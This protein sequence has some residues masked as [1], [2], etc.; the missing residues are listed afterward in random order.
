MIH[1]PMLAGKFENDEQIAAWFA[2]H[3]T[4]Y[5]TVKLDGIRALMVNGKL[6]SRTFKPIPNEWARTTLEKFLPEGSDG[7]LI[8]LGRPIQETTSAVMSQDGQPEGLVFAWFDLYSDK[9]YLERVADIEWY[10]NTYD[11]SQCPIRIMP[12]PVTA[13]NSLEELRGLEEQLVARGEEGVII[14]SATG[15]YKFGRSTLKEG[16][17]LKLKRFS[18]DTARA[19][20]FVELMHNDNEAEEDAFGRTKRSKCQENLVPMGTLGALVVEDI[21]TGVQFEIG[22]GFTANDRQEIWNNREVILGRLCDYKHFPV[23]KK[24]KP[25]HPVFVCWRHDLG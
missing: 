13:V 22:T 9:P 11:L 17:L 24:D 23:G 16:S 15:L 18:Q 10:M 25:R 6:V 1:K 5:C 2:V 14:R 8:L 20:G 3:K 21:E 7:E 19:I 12:L 4:A